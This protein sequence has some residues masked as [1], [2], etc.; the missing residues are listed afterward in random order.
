MIEDCV[1]RLF[2]IGSGRSSPL[3]PMLAG[4]DNNYDNLL[5][6]IKTN[7]VQQNKIQLSLML[8]RFWLKS[9][10]RF[11]LL[12]LVNDHRPAFPDRSVFERYL[13]GKWN[14]SRLGVCGRL[15]GDLIRY[16]LCQDYPNDTAI[17]RLFCN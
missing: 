7:L 8:R 16:K 17:N 6:L 5:N 9:R 12:W 10:G 3:D 1:E 15:V 14:C 2:G 11:V 13:S 4:Y